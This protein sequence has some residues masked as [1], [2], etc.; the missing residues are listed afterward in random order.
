MS[1]T[2][3]GA[4]PVGVTL[5]ALL[6]RKGHRVVSV[7]SRTRRSAHRAARLLGSPVGSD[8]LHDL[9]AKTTL[10]IVAVPEE[11][12]AHLALRAST[13]EHLPWRGVCV[14][15]TSGAQTSELL[16]PLSDRG[17]MTFALHP[18]Q[19]FPR[20]RRL[21]DQL[22]LMDGVA[23]AFQGPPRSRPLARRI[24]REFDGTMLVVPKQKKILYHAA[25][26]F[27]SNYPVVLLD[28]VEDLAK[29][30]SPDLGLEA[31][32]PLTESSIAHAAALSP[33][34]ALT[35]PVVRSS[36]GTVKGHRQALAAHSR[37]IE[38]IYRV[39]ALQALR[40][41]IRRGDVRG[42]GAKRLR[43]I[44]RKRP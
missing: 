44:L 17:S 18:V 42:A 41:A 26:V 27:A 20:S 35:G 3:V 25:C 9:S 21:H 32:R 10:V 28:I 30:V 19:S 22:L 12:I 33:A 34:A 37:E 31:F 15:H 43:D 1:V 39:L 7:I 14:F 5:A 6:V 40:M 16:N 2:L 29:A 4:G 13:L 24:V 11:E 8:D 38:E 36:G 23:Y